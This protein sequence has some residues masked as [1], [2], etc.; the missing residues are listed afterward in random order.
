MAGWD[1]DFDYFGK[2]IDGYVQYMQ[3]F[4]DVNK[5][6]APAA[7]NDDPTLADESF[8]PPRP[9]AQKAA[10]AKSAAQKATEAKSAESKARLTP[11]ERA[12][13]ESHFAAQEKKDRADTIRG[14]LA[15]IGFFLLL[16][17]LFHNV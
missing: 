5:K 9:A 6:D 4:N 10:A 14:I 1:Q 13:I 17:L 3:T 11:E 12:R 15:F 8:V 7:Q 16:V 2:G